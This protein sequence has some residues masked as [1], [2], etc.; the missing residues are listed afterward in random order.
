M[1]VFPFSRRDEKYMGAGP[2]D[3]IPTEQEIHDVVDEG[4]NDLHRDMKPR[5]LSV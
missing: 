3:G 2:D 5:Q 4:E 1:T